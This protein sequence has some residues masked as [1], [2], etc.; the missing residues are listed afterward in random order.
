MR[1]ITNNQAKEIIKTPMCNT[2]SNYINNNKKRRE[3]RSNVIIVQKGKNNK[4]Y[5][6]MFK[7]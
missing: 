2:H 4:N 7:L 1:T 5:T 6:E 3:E